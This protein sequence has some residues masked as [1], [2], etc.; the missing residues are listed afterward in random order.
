MGAT[1]ANDLNDNGSLSQVGSTNTGHMHRVHESS[2]SARIYL[3][4]V[5]TAPNGQFLASK[6]VLIT[7]VEGCNTYPTACINNA[8]YKILPICANSLDEERDYLHEHINLP[9]IMP[10]T[11]N[12]AMQCNWKHRF[13]KKIQILLTN[14]LLSL[15]SLLPPS[16][17]LWESV[18]ITYTVECKTRSLKPS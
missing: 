8:I 9:N 12:G 18:T 6:A 4:T 13:C 15:T 3:A 7:A 16:H 1:Q 14:A 5:G 17:Q 2:S 11:I 10:S